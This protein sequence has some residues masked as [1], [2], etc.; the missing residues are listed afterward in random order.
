[1]AIT[2]LLWLPLNLFSLTSYPAPFGDEALIGSVSAEV[3]RSGR[4][5]LPVYGAAGGIYDNYKVYHLYTL[6]LT[7]VF[8]L[9]GIGLAQGRAFSVLGALAGAWLLFFLGWR[10]YGA[11]VGAASAALY[12][13][14]LRVLGPSHSVRPDLWVNAAG[15]TCFLVFWHAREA[16]RPWP[17]FLAGLLAAAA[18]D[19]YVT[20]LYASLAV[21]LTALI[22]FRRRTDWKLLGLY[23]LGGL[24]GTAYWFIAHLLP[25]PAATLI[26]WQY[27]S[28][29]VGLVE[30]PNLRLLFNLNLFIIQS[31][32]IGHSRLGGAE[33]AYILAGLISLAIRNRAADRFMLL[34]WIMLWLGVLYPYKGLTHLIQMTPLFSLTIAAFGLTAGQWLARRLPFVAP[35]S[36]LAV[37]LYAPL[38]AGYVAGTIVLGWQSRAI[39]YEEYTRQLRALIPAGSSVMGEGTWWW[40]LQ[41]HLYTA[42][43]YLLYFTLAYPDVSI[44]QATQTVLAERGVNVIL[45]DGQFSFHNDVGNKT[46]QGALVDYAHTH[47]RLAGVVELYGYGVEVGGPGIKRTEV[48]VCGSR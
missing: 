36:A 48:F 34:G 26:Q 9:F 41:D 24:I 25:D 44:S 6:A 38:L 32:L 46:L 20:T 19:V 31:G 16:R 8:R 35:A 11:M 3:L 10:L 4:F 28:G 18:V 7:Q 1:M 5:A 21:S 40:G 39:N 43:D 37:A 33:T 13:F 42:E 14:S 12:L 22:E 27:L 30:S 45:L 2:S 17:V 15:V 47:C 23:A 29:K